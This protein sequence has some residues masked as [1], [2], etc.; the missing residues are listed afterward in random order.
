M[1]GAGIAQFNRRHKAEDV[2]PVLENEFPVDCATRY[3]AVTAP[4]IRGFA[5]ES[6]KPLIANLLEAW[7]KGG[8][9]HMRRRKNCLRKSVRIRRVYIT[10]HDFILHQ[11]I[12]DIGGF[13][14]G[15]TNHCGVE[16]GMALIDKGIYRDTFI[17]T[18]IFE[19]ITRVQ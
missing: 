10:L 3:D 13:S 17:L 19:R 14:V 16:Q 8:I 6:I 18:K 12:N 11:A 9:N 15:C 5:G 7:G 1:R 4:L 2:I